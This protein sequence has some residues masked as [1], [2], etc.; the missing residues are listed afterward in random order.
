MHP[1]AVPSPTV[2][3]LMAQLLLIAIG[4]RLLLPIVQVRNS[5]AVVIA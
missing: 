2:P 5:A 1:S 4:Y 3:V